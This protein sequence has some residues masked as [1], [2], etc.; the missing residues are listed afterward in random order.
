[1]GARFQL[2]NKAAYYGFDSICSMINLN[3]FIKYKNSSN[4]LIKVVLTEK[5]TIEWEKMRKLWKTEFGTYDNDLLGF[6]MYKVSNEP[7]D[8]FLFHH[9]YW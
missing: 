2:L 4:H 8:L 5:F 6:F 9:C 1:M 3:E 7:I